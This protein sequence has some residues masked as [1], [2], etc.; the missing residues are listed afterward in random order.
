MYLLIFKIDGFIEDKRGNK[1]LQIAF[2]DNH[3]EV[4]RSILSGVKSCIEKINN[5]KS[6]EYEKDYMRI[7]FNSDNK[8][9]LDKQLKFLTVTTVIRFAFEEDGK[10]YPQVF[11][12]DCL[13]E[14]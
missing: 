3:N 2:T 11:L 10:Y 12:D 8:L 7:K 6:G 5:N 9:L 1:Y 14:L 4:L 13:Y